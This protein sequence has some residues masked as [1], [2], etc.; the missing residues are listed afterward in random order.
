MSESNNKVFI[1]KLAAI[2]FAITFIATLLLTLCNYLTKDRIAEL[3]AQ[4]AEKAKQEVIANASFEEVEI[5]DDKRALW[6][7]DFAFKAAFKAEKDGEFAGYCINVAP[8]GFGG[9]IDMIVGIDKEMNFTG[10]K[11]ISMAETPGLGAKA[12]EKSFYGQYSNGKKGELSVV[13]NNPNPAENEIQAISGATIT[14]KAVTDGANYA[15]EIVKM[16]EKEAE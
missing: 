9:A 7:K 12:Q 14:S 16:L 6:E 4:N 8:T 13:K 3:S 5:G 11:I 10:V 1:I 15:L 2:L